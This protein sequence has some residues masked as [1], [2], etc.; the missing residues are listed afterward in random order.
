MSM[1]MKHFHWQ[2]FVKLS[3]GLL[4][5]NAIRHLYDHDISPR[6]LACHQAHETNEHLFQCL[7][8]TDKI[9][10]IFLKVSVPDKCKHFCYQTTQKNHYNTIIH[11]SFKLQLD[12][13][14]F[15]AG[16]SL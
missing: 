5:T 9:Q 12:G 16:K 1:L 10:Q 8:Y 14:S 11:S 6:C 3:Q 2:L 15:S 4:P 7:C 13:E